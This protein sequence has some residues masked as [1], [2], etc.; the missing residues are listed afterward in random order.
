MRALFSIWSPASFHDCFQDSGVESPG[1]AWVKPARAALS[2]GPPSFVICFGRSAGY[3]ALFSMRVPKT[4]TEAINSQP[5]TVEVVDPSKTQ[6]TAR[7]IPYSEIYRESTG[8]RESPIERLQR[9][10]DGPQAD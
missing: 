3:R 8:I 1:T 5:A 4:L 6:T 10:S 7:Q 9:I 2:S